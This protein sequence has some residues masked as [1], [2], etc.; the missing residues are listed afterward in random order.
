[1]TLRD[2]AE[3]VAKDEYCADC[4]GSRYR[5]D[6]GCD[7]NCEGFQELVEEIL[8]EWAEENRKNE[9]INRADEITEDKKLFEGD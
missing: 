2:Q 4:N 8:Q 6:S 1:M 5:K 7:E 3:Q 9:A